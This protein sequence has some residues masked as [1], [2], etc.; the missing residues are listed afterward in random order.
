MPNGLEKIIELIKKT[1]NNCVVL[2]HEGNPA[3]VVLAF[4]DYEKMALNKSDI[5]N[6]SEEQLLDKVNAEIAVWKAANQSKE[7]EDWSEI[8]ERKEAEKPL[9]DDKNL[10]DKAKIT[11]EEVRSAQDYFFEPVD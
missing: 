2:D 6:L 10:L 11:E 8:T 1:N 5:S 3:F 4:G 9:I 7:F